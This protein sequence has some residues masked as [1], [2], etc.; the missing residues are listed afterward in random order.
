[1]RVI[2]MGRKPA[3]SDGLKYLIKKDIDVAV[4]V[5]PPEN[6]PCFWQGRLIDTALQFGIPV[7]TDDE[8]YYYTSEEGKT[9]GKRYLVEDIDLV[10]SFLFW[11]RIKKPLIDLPKIG[12][13]NFH[14]A[15]LPD[16]RGV[17]GYTF[18]I[19]NNLSYW[20]VSAHFVDESLDTG[21][22]IKMNRFDINASEET[23]FSL[24]QK[25][26]DYLV[27]LFK[28]VINIT[29]AGKALPRNPQGEG[30][31]INKEDFEQ[32][33]KVR[34]NDSLEEIERKIRAF[35]YPPYSGASVEIQGKEFTLVNDEVLKDI[36]NKYHHR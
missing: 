11:K 18:A 25:S 12:C 31:Y 26:Q 16:F 30:Q 17:A 35:W 28:E 10:I 32:L 29:L 23:A 24:E 14:P 33:R 21:D 3:A 9:S 27:Q 2:Y 8:L 7:A 13:I 1:M 4:V 19:Y 5:A 15:P 36:G 6:Q 22:I 34:T 20:G